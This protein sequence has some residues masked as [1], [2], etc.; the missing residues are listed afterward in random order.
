LGLVDL[1]GLCVMATLWSTE[2]SSIV[3]GDLGLW[4]IEGITA[5]MKLKM[6]A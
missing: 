6:A 3:I 1:I 2:L 4:G 5:A